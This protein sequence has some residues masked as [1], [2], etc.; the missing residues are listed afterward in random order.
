MG[1]LEA[2]VK[3]LWGFLGSESVKRIFLDIAADLA[4]Q[5]DNTIDDQLILELRKRLLVKIQEPQ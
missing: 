3:T 5:T 2:L 4:A 1:L